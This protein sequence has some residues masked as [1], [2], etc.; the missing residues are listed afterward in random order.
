MANDSCDFPAAHS[1][2]TAWF[3]VDRDGHVAFFDTGLAGAVPAGASLDDD[4]KILLET[5]RDA[6]PSTE[7]IFDLDAFRFVQGARDQHAFPYMTEIVLFLESKDPIEATVD[8]LDARIVDATIE[9]GTNAIALRFEGMSDEARAIVQGLHETG[10]CLGCYSFETPVLDDDADD[11]IPGVEVA[12]HGIYH[13]LHTREEA[14]A[15]AYSPFVKPSRPLYIT[16]LPAEVAKKAIV[17]E[18]RFAETPRLQPAELWTCYGWNA[19]W[20]ALDGKTLTS[21]PGR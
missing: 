12:E 16:D 8:D 14:L 6:V 21:F 19:G 7:P 17:F 15:E 4:E 3:A 13:Y 9:G 10:A 20:L 5:L 2:D 1:M 11:V 18:G